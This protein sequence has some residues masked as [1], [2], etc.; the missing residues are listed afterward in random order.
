[1]VEDSKLS[2]LQTSHQPS[3]PVFDNRASAATSQT[4]T[5]MMQKFI[6]DSEGLSREEQV[7]FFWDR[8]DA[9]MAE[10]EQLQK[11]IADL[12]AEVKQSADEQL[13]LTLERD[14]AVALVE[15]QREDP[16]YLR[17]NG[18]YIDEDGHMCQLSSDSDDEF[19]YLYD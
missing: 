3:G 6:E 15:D 16:D 11:Y 7:Q 17:E 13:R 8:K 5:R 2:S 1:M 18:L 19:L 4:S 10:R 14:A 12:K 9:F